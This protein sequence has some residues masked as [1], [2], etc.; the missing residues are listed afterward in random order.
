MWAKYGHFVWIAIALFILLV[1]VKFNPIRL[2]WKNPYVAL[3]ILCMGAAFL[4]AYQAGRKDVVDK[5]QKD[6]TEGKA[7][8]DNL[9]ERLEEAIKK[10]NDAKEQPE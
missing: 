1:D 8:I 4:F 3:G 2:Q 7:K 6:F 5:Y 9:T 10:A